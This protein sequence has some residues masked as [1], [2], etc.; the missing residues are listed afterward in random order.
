MLSECHLRAGHY[1][2][3]VK[4]ATTTVLVCIYYY[5]FVKYIFVFFLLPPR[6]N[7]PHSFRI[8]TIKIPIFAEKISGGQFY[9]RSEKTHAHNKNTAYTMGGWWAGYENCPYVKYRHYYLDRKTKS[10]HTTKHTALIRDGGGQVMIMSKSP[11]P[12]C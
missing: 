4:I 3:Y 2:P 5:F 12:L 10:T 11:L 6:K 9:Y 7:M 1:R 8:P